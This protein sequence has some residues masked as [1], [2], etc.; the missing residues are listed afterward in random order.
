MTDAVATG[1]FAPLTGRQARFL[2]GLGHG[3][4]PRVT[5][6]KEG[7]TDAVA[8]SLDANLSAHELVKVRIGPGCA[9]DRRDVAGDLAA[10][11]GARVAQILGRTV[12]LYRAAGKPVILL[13]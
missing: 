7:V 6:G 8:A 1:E 5:V 10:R 9:R 12:L 4:E 13:P 11:S 3:L 2:R